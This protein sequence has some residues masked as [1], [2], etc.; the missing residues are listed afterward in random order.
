MNNMLN[1]ENSLRVLQQILDNKR[2]KHENEEK[3]KE[4]EFNIA[5]IPT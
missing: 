1:T 3:D 2:L 4:N 5:Q